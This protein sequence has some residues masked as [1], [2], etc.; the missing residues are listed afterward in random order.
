MITFPLSLDAFFAGLPIASCSFRLPESLQVDETGGG[1][2]LVASLGVRL[3]E[4]EVTLTADYHSALSGAEALISVVRDAGASFLAF[5]PQQ[6]FPAADPQGL[7]LG[8]SVPVISAQPSARSLVLSNL[9]AG[10]VLT[11]GDFLSFS[12]GPA[13]ERTALHQVVIGGAANSSGVSPEILVTPAIRPGAS[14]G[15]AVSLVRPVARMRYVPGS[16]RASAFGKMIGQG[17][18]FGFRQTLRG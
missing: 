12:Y 17:P 8:T 18:S 7:I 4:G 9:P 13:P 16:Y 3:W 5:P 11:A 15:A 10:Y 1:E 6:P 14:L 2:V